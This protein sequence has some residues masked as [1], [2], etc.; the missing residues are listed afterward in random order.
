MVRRAWMG[1]LLLSAVLAGRVMAQEDFSLSV[2]DRS[3]ALD[4]K[5][6]KK[7]VKDASGAVSAEN[8]RAIDAVAHN[9]MMR[10]TS[11]VNRHMKPG[12]AEKIGD[13]LREASLF[14]LQDL[15]APPKKISDSQKDYI[16]V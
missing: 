8:Q 2:P 10:I 15:Q 14:V 6:G 7:P 4:M 9:C 16:Q 3:L 13:L 5:T 12:Q 1:L 11:E